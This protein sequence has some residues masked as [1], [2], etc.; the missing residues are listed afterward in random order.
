MLNTLTFLTGVATLGMPVALI[1]F[2]PEMDNP[3]A[4]VNSVMTVSGAI[5]FV[6]SLA[7]IIGMPIWA[8]GLVVQFWRP[9]YVP[10]VVVTAVA[11]TFGP[12]LDQAA[13]AARRAD[14]YLWRIVIFSVTKVPL[15]LVFALWLG[16]AL[17]QIR[18]LG[19]Y[20]SWSIAFGVSVLAAAF[21]FIPH[22]IKGYRPTP[23]FSRERLRPMF[24]FSLVERAAAVLGSAGTLLLPLL[25]IN[26]LRTNP[27]ESPPRTARRSS[28]PRPSSP[29]AS[30][31]FPRPRCRPS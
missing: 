27:W 9:E 2:L 24:G 8:P 10:I 17:G 31:P 11:Y 3:S 23:R 14:L 25:I 12:I 1:R 6:L 20:M 29:G 13:I 22:A 21:V 18:V 4:L 16:A 15:P 5:V 19:I 30:P 26:T 28:T 7:F